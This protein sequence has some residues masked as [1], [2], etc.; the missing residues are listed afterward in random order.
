MPRRGIIKKRKTPADPFYGSTLVA[1][2]IN[3]FLR[4]GKKTT[5][6]KVVYGTMDILKAKTKEDPLKVLEKALENIRP[7][8]E[9]KSRRVGGANYQVPIEVSSGRSFSLGF[10]WLIKY[11]KVRGGKSMQEKLSAEI[12]D[13]INNRGG[14]VKK[15]EDTHKMAEANRAFAHYK[16]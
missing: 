14:A 8:L 1:R 13:A 3:L 7:F 12:I 10:R 5:A 16:W 15:R 4:Q 6:Q 2:F 11:A 9:T